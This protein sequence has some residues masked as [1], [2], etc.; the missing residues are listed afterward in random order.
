MLA[1]FCAY[2]FLKNQRYFEPFFVLA[3]L[4]KN[5]SF[6]QIG[7]L[8]AFRDLMINFAEIPSGSVADMYGRRRSMLLSFSAYIISFLLFAIS[9]QYYSFFIAMIFYAIG[10]AFRTGTHKAMIFS[11]LRLQGMEAQRLKFYGLTRSW[12]KLGSAASAVISGIFVFVFKEFTVVFY[13]S[14]IPYVLS[15]LNIAAYPVE[16]DGGNNTK[17]SVKQ[18][19]GHT[20][21]TIK[22]SFHSPPLR[23]LIFESMGFEGVFNTMKEYLQPVLQG[24]AV[25]VLAN[26]FITDNW[27]EAQKSVML[28]VPVY[29]ILYILSAVISRRAEKIIHYLGEEFTAARKC[30]LIFLIISL[31]IAGAGISNMLPVV[32]VAF[33][34]LFM[35]QNLWR[36]FLISRFD[37]RTKANTGA[38]VLSIESQAKRLASVVLAPILGLGVDWMQKNAITGEFGLVGAMGVL[39]GL[40]FL[41]INRSR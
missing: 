1:R 7:S 22:S 18:L 30:W 3:L 20:W 29:T 38:T 31:C 10:D 40:L 2:G 21:L 4:E 19:F 34:F 24:T 8:F 5:L 28:V 32:I 14:C 39:S 33:V 17:V 26:F 25:V 13:L 27:T 16:L 41:Y 23:H 35:L 37:S 9:T 36:P 15:I 6:F 12:S 11:W